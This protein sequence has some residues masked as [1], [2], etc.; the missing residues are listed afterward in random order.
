MN[1]LPE[2]VAPKGRP[3]IT[4]RAKVAVEETIASSDRAYFYLP[5]SNAAHMEMLHAYTCVCKE[6][7]SV[8]IFN[9]EVG[10]L[11][12]S[13]AW[14]RFGLKAHL[15]KMAVY[16]FY[17]ILSTVALLAFEELLD[18]KRHGA[19]YALVTL[20][21]AIDAYFIKE[22][23]QQFGVSPLEYF[24]DFWNVLDFIVIFTNITANVLRLVYLDDN[25]VIDVLLSVSSIVAYFNILYYLRAFEATGPLVSMILRIS[26]DMTYLIV[27]VILILVGFSQAFWL[28]SRHVPGLPFATFEG[29][30]LNSF[31]FMLGGFDP[32]AFA[33][34]RLYRFAIAL[35]CLYM[36]I[37]SILLLN[38][39][40][41][42]MGDSY[43]S[44]KEKGL[45]QWKLE[46][47]QIVTEMQ[48]SMPSEDR[49]CTDVVSTAH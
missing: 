43:G 30:L 33:D 21:L 32:T 29:S 11:A 28:V 14:R 6:L 22:E 7:D 41:A 35:S 34:T 23:V 49:Q 10:Q 20:Q 3:N 27:V 45:A 48:G 36:L 18:T 15:L 9:S 25:M 47:A 26:K 4:T 8:D 24:S 39:L 17:V 40:I 2:P 31:V 42:L 46:Q 5:I 19:A 16:F 44:V 12:L 38:L 37:V 1:P 13:Y